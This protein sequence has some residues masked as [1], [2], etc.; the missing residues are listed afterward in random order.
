MVMRPSLRHAPGE[1]IHHLRFSGTSRK[2]APEP[3]RWRGKEF[4]PMPLIRLMI[5]LASALFASGANAE[6]RKAESANFVVYSTASEARLRERIL[7]LEDFDRL[8]R[9][10]VAGEQAPSPNRLH[11]YV[12][13][14]SRDLRRVRDL[15]ANVGGF[16]TASADGIAAFISD[17]ASDRQNSILFHEYAHHFMLQSARTAYPAWYIEGFAEY[18][19]TAKFTKESIDIGNFAPE[20]AAWLVGAQWLPWERVLGGTS[21]GLTAEGAAM[22]YAQS[23]LLTHYFYSNAERQAAHRKY[24]ANVAKDGPVRAMQTATGMNLDQ[25]TKELARYIRGGRINYRRMERPAA[26]PVPVKITALPRSADDLLVHEAQLRIGGRSVNAQMLRSLR[27]AA[28]K[29]PNDP[30]AQRVLAHAELLHGDS[31]VALRLLEGLMAASPND[32]ELMYLRGRLHLAAAEAGEDG[33]SEQAR[34]WFAKAHRAD[35]NH[36]QT[37]YRYAQSLGSGAEAVSENTM[38]VL[39]LA[40]QLAPQVSEIRFNAGSVLI[41]RGDFDVAE[42]VL[43]PLLSDPHDPQGAATARKMLDDARARAASPRPGGRGE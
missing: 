36:Y 37:L 22:F 20:R 21:S 3:L 2:N 34:I 40:H 18:F 6:W 33:A 15:G 11:V 27:A 38:N 14:R 28:A 1:A 13:P 4:A 23:W 10:L 19:M 31:A 16:Y 30:F 24:L 26:Q 42:E 41:A 39:L 29:Y 25:F 35:A 32:A 5:V 43:Q 9:L 7:L 12:L 17:E 8:L